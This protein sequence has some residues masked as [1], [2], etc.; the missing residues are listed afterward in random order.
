MKISVRLRLGSMNLNT[1]EK[2]NEDFP[3]HYRKE[4]ILNLEENKCL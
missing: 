3:H 4:N 2:G 1:W